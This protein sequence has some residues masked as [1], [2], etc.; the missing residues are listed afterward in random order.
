MR[1]SGFIFAQ[2]LTWNRANLNLNEKTAGWVL[3]GGQYL[4]WQ[5]QLPFEYLPIY[6]VS[7]RITGTRFLVKSFFSGVCIYRKSIFR[8]Y[9]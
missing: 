8:K 9:L 7:Q 5:K 3:T 2:P 1:S 6:V 4:N